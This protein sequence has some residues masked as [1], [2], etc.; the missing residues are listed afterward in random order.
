MKKVLFLAMAIIANGFAM[1][2]TIQWTIR[3]GQIQNVAG[4]G[5]QTSGLALLVQG[6][7]T[8]AKAMITT[9]MEGGW[10][11]SLAL[12]GGQVNPAGGAPM[13]PDDA[14]ITS[15]SL[16]NSTETSFYVV[17]FDGTSLE[18]STHFLITSVLTG[19]TGAGP[20]T[21][22]DYL[23]WAS[24]ESVMDGISGGWLALTAVPEPTALALLALG[25]A[26]VALRRRKCA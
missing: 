4:T 19:K 17:I 8:D 14:S 2:G 23:V 5:L 1:A 6:D 21:P 15:P 7:A 24:Q 26:G 25:V 3:A 11:N 18:N 16:P 10:D 20:E 12:G 13:S 22:P 9:I